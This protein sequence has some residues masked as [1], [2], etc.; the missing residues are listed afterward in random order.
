MKFA[1]DWCKAN[2]ICIQTSKIPY[3]RFKKS[4]STIEFNIASHKL[5][6]GSYFDYSGVLI[7]KH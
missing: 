4:G 6:A 5:Q 2:K 7:D 1:G 3:I